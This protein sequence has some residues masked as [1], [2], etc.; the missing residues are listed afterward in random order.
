LI[1]SSKIAF[2][3][4]RASFSRDSS[5]KTF[6]LLGGLCDPAGTTKNMVKRPKWRYFK[7][8]KNQVTSWVTI[9]FELI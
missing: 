6:D 3:Q 9:F 4:K 8:F 2:K 1:F 7:G 5:F